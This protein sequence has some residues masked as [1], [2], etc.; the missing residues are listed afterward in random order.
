MEITMAVA[1]GAVMGTALGLV[2]TGGAILAVPALVYLF[3]F[4]ALQ[5]TTASLVIVI[6]AAAVSARARAKAGQIAYQ[7]ALVLWT[8]GLVGNFIGAIASKSASEFILLTGISI[9]ILGASISMWVRSFQGEIHPKE[10]H[11]IVLPIMGTLIGFI[12]GFFGVGGAFLVVPTLILA[13]GVSAHIA[14]GTGLIVM[15][16]NSTT[17]LLVRYDTWGKVD[18]QIPLIMLTSAVVIAWFAAE[19]GTRLKSKSLERGFA[20][21]LLLVGLFTFIETIFLT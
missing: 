8:I 15:L 6:A 5:A 4:S 13:F 18:W 11:P 9:I 7:R 2:G 1:I 14:A 20:G 17:A 3:N 19:K 16:L 10:R 21:L 12:A